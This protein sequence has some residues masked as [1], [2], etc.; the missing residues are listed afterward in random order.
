V[1]YSERDLDE[2]MKYVIELMGEAQTEIHYVVEQKKAN[3]W[4]C[5]TFPE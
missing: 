5:L 3:S 1:S 4:T 2:I